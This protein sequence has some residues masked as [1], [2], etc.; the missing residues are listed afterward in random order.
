MLVQH[1]SSQMNQFVL[2]SPSATTA[3]SDSSP[4]AFNW[5]TSSVS[6]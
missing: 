4:V 6:M 1:T 2:S 5:E 3:R